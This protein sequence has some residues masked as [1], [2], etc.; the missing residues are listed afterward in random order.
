MPKIIYDL[1]IT[2]LYW[3][4]ERIEFQSAP[5]FEA[6][7]DSENAR[8]PPGDRLAERMAWRSLTGPIGP[9]PS[10]D[11]AA[12]ILGYAD[13]LSC[14]DPRIWSSC[15]VKDGRGRPVDLRA[16]LAWIRRGGLHRY[17]LRKLPPGFEPCRGVTVPGTGHIRGRYRDILRKPRT[18][19]EKRAALGVKDDVRSGGM[20]VRGRLRCNLP[21]A[22]D[23]VTKASAGRSW[24]LHRRTRWRNQE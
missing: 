23:E 12:T 14:G 6:W 11:V 4:G 18:V 2:V 5:S 1:P 21:D 13:A 9:V 8:L 19:S 16:T 7:L 22:Y 17:A 10:F 15:V 20:Q 3:S 24:K